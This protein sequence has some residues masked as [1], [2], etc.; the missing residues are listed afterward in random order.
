MRQFPWRIV[1]IL[2]V[3][4]AILLPAAAMAAPPVV[5]T[6]PWVA[7]NPLIAHDTYPGKAVTLKGTSDVQGANFTYRWEFGDGSANATGTVT[8]MWAIEASHTYAGTVGDIFAATL[9]VTNTTTAESGSATYLVKMQSKSLEVEA[10]VAIDEGLWYLHKNFYRYVNGGK[11][12]GT[13]MTS[14][15]GGVCGGYIALQAANATAFFVNGHRVDGLPS[16]PYTDTVQRAM[17]RFFDS[18]S[19]GAAPSQTYTA[20]AYGAA[21]GTIESDCSDCTPADPSSN[22]LFL[23]IGNDTYQMG[24][25]VT[26]VAASGTPAWVT[27]TGGA[28]VLGRTYRAILQDLVDWY[29]YAQEERGGCS[30]F[31]GWHYGAQ[32]CSADNST[33]QWGAIALLG[34]E[35]FG[36]G[37]YN[38]LYGY[39]TD[40][41]IQVPTVVRQANAYWL[42]TSFQQFGTG[43]MYGAFGYSSAGYYPWGYWAVTPSGLVQLA[44]SGLG[45][46]GADAKWEKTE[47]FVRDSFG[48]T[49]GAANA[50]KDYYYGLYAFVKA[51]LLH[52][53]EG[54]GLKSPITLLGDDLDWY[55]AETSVGAPTDGVART[56]INDQSGGHWNGHY[57]SSEQTYFETSWAIQMLNRTITES[58]APV[59][60][61]KAIPNPA[62]GGGL[63]TLDGSAS[64]HQDP[65]KA[66]VKWEWDVGN[67]GSVDFVGPVV[68]WTAPSLLG[69][70]IVKLRV[71]DN[72][73]VGA[74]DDAIITVEVSIPP[75]PP[76]ADVGGPY[77]FCPGKT[78]WYLDAS[79]SVNPDEGVRDPS[80][81]SCPGDTIKSYAWD[82]NFDGTYEL[83]NVKIP[84]VT[85]YFSD[86]GT[87][88]YA[89][90]LKVTD[91]TSLSFPGK[92]DLFGTD[93]GQVNVL[94]ATDPKCQGCTV[95]TLR[96]A[97]RQVQLNWTNVLA[98][99]YAVYR[100]E[101]AGGPYTK[102][103]AV[104]G[105]QLLFINSGLTVGKTYFWVVRPLAANLEELCQ[106]N[107]VTALIRGR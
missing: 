43:G 75:L 74:Q 14:C 66:I 94:A 107:Q 2:A 5:K 86:K 23:Y 16:N 15:G 73:G 83:A 95:V 41:G 102:I 90:R 48:N 35:G 69:N 79:G 22:G 80:C 88:S 4:A 97:G 33:A 103:A 51:M 91:S 101:I 100:G 53:D 106:S 87:G 68:T 105:T 89:I 59:A 49:G 56:L 61:A 46:G 54:S 57:Y 67:D 40:A 45:R 50:I 77:N 8:N 44:F 55:A 3:V 11:D 13:W 47:K 62:V 65:S 29:V 10:N 9:T 37:Q 32:Y 6:V 31:G 71:T 30:G 81:P 70:Y 18:I 28:N 36:K 92:S 20:G 34:A 38:G 78:P 96:A 17:R 85:A 25:V 60:V 99:G 104:P 42:R 82:L 19:S 1:S 24:M 72:F 12:Y 93:V 7:T 21:L 63:V 26:A 39:G 76:T 64:F 52:V 27:D 84:D 98:A 58:G